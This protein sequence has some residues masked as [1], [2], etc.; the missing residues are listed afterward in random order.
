MNKTIILVT[1]LVTCLWTYNSYALRVSKPLT[2]TYPITEE[3]VSQLNKY[4]EEIWLIQ[5]GRFEIDVVTSPKTN[6]KT[7]EIW[8]YNNSGTYSLQ[9]KAGGNVRSA[10][11]SP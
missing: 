9:V 8:I 10:T 1:A 4:L 6:A 3:Q 7:G 11:L 5:N 2:L